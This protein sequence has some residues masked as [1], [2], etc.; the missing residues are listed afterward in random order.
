[1][2]DRYAEIADRIAIDWLRSLEALRRAQE[3]IVESD[4]H[5]NFSLFA[6]NILRAELTPLLDAA[7]VIAKKFTTEVT[8]C[9][10]D[11]AANLRAELEKWR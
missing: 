7:E 3:F 2:S 4:A 6:A 10:F 9:S 8:H 1:M 11:E 5:M